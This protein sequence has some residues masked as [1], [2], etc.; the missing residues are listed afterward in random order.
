MTGTNTTS[1]KALN[2]ESDAA[3]VLFDAR[4]DLAQSLIR[5]VAAHRRDAITFGNHTNQRIRMHPLD[6]LSQDGQ[7]I[8]VIGLI[9]ETDSSDSRS[10]P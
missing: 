2:L 8:E 4:I 6:F 10:S 5:Q 1:W 9:D 7:A 3:L